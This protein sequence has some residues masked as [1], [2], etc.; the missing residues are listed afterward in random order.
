[1]RGQDIVNNWDFPSKI[2]RH[3]HKRLVSKIT[4]Q[5]Q[6]EIFVKTSLR[7]RLDC[8]VDCVGMILLFLL[9]HF[10]PYGNSFPRAGPF[11]QLFSQ[12]LSS[13]TLCS[14]LEIF[15][16][17]NNLCT[18]WHSKFQQVSTYAFCSWHVILTPKWNCG[19]PKNLCKCTES[20]SALS[21]NTSIEW[22]HY[23]S[24]S[25]L[26][27]SLRLKL[28]AGGLSEHQD[29]TS[30]TDRCKGFFSPLVSLKSI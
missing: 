23:L 8:L 14:C 15:S 2:S 10:L 5:Y 24:C 30:D 13:H 29:K 7:D 22:N 26:V 6:R 20:P 19:S 11:T 21:P 12:S 16:A 3:C 9:L 1:M 4:R 27:M 18:F 17:P 28:Y 25:H